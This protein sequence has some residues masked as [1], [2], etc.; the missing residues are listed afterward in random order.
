MKND[1]ITTLKIENNNKYIYLDIYQNK[2]EEIEYK[3]ETNKHILPYNPQ[4]K[5]QNYTHNKINLTKALEL[6]EKESYTDGNITITCINIEYSE[7]ENDEY[8][9]TLNEIKQEYTTITGTI[10]TLNENAIC[11]III[12]NDID[13]NKFITQKIDYEKSIIPHNNEINQIIKSNEFKTLILNL[14]DD[15]LEFASEPYIIN[16]N[17]KFYLGDYQ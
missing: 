5:L 14:C 12:I 6:K 17:V 13:E 9:P 4:N 16:N 11:N 3:Y 15:D 10:K 7:P 8:L 2:K 1:K